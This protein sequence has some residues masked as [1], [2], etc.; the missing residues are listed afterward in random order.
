MADLGA[1]LVGVSMWLYY[2]P[3][4]V[5]HSSRQHQPLL[6]QHCLFVCKLS[7]TYSSIFFILMQ[8]KVMA[9]EFSNLI[10]SINQPPFYQLCDFFK[11]S[12]NSLYVCF[13]S[14]YQCK[15]P[16]TVQQIWQLLF[17]NCHFFPLT[18]EFKFQG[19]SQAPLPR[20]D[21]SQVFFFFFFFK[22]FHSQQE[23]ILSSWPHRKKMPHL[24]SL[25]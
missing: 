5:I 18:I 12:Q 16:F 8:N 20:E 24:L 17:P 23:N 21:K 3:H 7:N 10:L 25:F 4:G 19:C 11:A 9:K 6:V 13:P 22:P 1:A 2:Y 15:L 14:T